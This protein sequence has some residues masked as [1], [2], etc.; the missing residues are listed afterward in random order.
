MLVTFSLLIVWFVFYAFALSPLQNHH[1]QGVLY[2]QFR[3]QLAEETAPTGGVISPG[4]PVALMSMPS[5]HL[6][7]EVVVEGT[8][9]GDL[10]AGPGHLRDTVLPGQTGLSVIMGRKELF[11]APFGSITA[12]RPGDRITFITAE[13]ES[14]YKVLDVRQAGETGPAPLATNAGGLILVTSS[15]S[16][17]SKGKAVF[18]DAA[19][20]STPYGNQAGGLTSV[21]AAELPMKGDTSVLYVLVLW[22]P[23]LVAAVMTVTWLYARWG[24]WQ[25][26]VTGVP[27]LLAVL[28]G[29]SKVAIQLLPNLT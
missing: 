3:Q 11:G 9:S 2:S 15:G 7:R 20:T 17:W 18:V 19:L 13:G 27:L 8:T 6:Y 12:A 22:L 24:R 1:D 5:A 16:G 21:P 28:W 26:W 29:T 10:T 23:L 4:A 14:Q 25:A